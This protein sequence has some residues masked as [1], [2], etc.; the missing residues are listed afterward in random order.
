MCMPVGTLGN[1]FFFGKAAD[2]ASELHH[3]IRAFGCFFGNLP[4]AERVRFDIQSYIASVTAERP[5]LIFVMLD[6][7]GFSDAVTALRA[8]MCFPFCTFDTDAMIASKS[9]RRLRTTICAQRTVGAN[10]NT[11]FT[12]AAFFTAINTVGTVF[13]AVRANVI[14]TISAVIAVTT[15]AV[16][17]VNACPTV[18]AKFIDASGTFTAV[19][20]NALRAVCADSAAVLADFRAFAAQIALLAEKIVRTFPTDVAGNAE[21]VTTCR[22][23]LSAVRAEIGAVFAALAA[24]T[25]HSAVPAKSAG[26]AK[27]V[28]IGAVNA[29]A[30]LCTKLSVRAV[31]AFLTAFLANDGTVRASAAANANHLHTVIA[32][33][34]V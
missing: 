20:T 27:A 13:S 15:H 3:T 32:D 12:L 14:R 22:A 5:V 7:P 33:T 2:F 6:L 16:G 18:R 23:D 34:A 8:V 4:L 28:R 25:Y 1:S 31:R 24:G 10:F 29:F 26:Q 9:L 11:V 19:I 17:A 30:A 21:L